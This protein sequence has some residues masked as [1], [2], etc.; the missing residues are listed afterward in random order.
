MVSFADTAVIARP[1]VRKPALVSRVCISCASASVNARLGGR[2]RAG[3]TGGRAGRMRVAEMADREAAV[4]HRGI[5]S[6]FTALKFGPQQKTVGPARNRHP[7]LRAVALG[8]GNGWPSAAPSRRR[9]NH[10]A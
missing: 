2:G 9:S 7:Q 8:W 10:A 1:V 5:C 6:S 4:V 3:G